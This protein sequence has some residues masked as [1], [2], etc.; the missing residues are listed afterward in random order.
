MTAE[1]FVA[2]FLK[3]RSVIPTLEREAANWQKVDQIKSSRLLVK[4][5]MIEH[6]LDLAQEAYNFGAVVK[7]QHNLVRAQELTESLKP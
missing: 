5:R 7:A 3:V 1:E 2:A 6:R 4:A